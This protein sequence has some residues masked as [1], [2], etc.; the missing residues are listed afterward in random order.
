MNKQHDVR[1][2]AG[3]DDWQLEDSAMDL[4][5]KM[6]RTS[7][8][9]DVGIVDDMLADLDEQRIAALRLQD[10]RIVNI[11][12][13]DIRDELP[14]LFTEPG[15]VPAAPHDVGRNEVTTEHIPLVEE[16]MNVGK[17]Q[18]ELGSV[19]IQTKVVSEGVSEDIVLREERVTVTRGEVNELISA[20]DADKLFQDDTIVLEETAE[21]AVV[22]KEAVVTGEVV[23]NK[24][25]GFRTERVE[26]TVRHT[27]VDVDR[28]NETNEPVKP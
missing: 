16:R 12:T 20:D 25:T 4:R 6:L 3:L 5:G 23:V 1:Q 17:R 28:D 24:K 21:R 10:G 27:E 19:R 18:V 14:V 22:S 15:N 7:D 8:G 2:L 9:E 11:D 26:D 13:V